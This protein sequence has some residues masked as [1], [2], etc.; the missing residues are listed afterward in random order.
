MTIMSTF[1]KKLLPGDIVLADQGFDI[2]ELIAMEGAELHIPACTRGKKQLS[3]KEVELSKKIEN[4]QIHV[5]RVSDLLRQK[6]YTIVQSTIPITML[7]N[8]A[9]QE[10]PTLD[11]IVNVAC[12]LTNLCPSVVPF[13]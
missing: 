13:H 9:R 12:A 7:L 4:V 5:E 8:K 3:G 10:K 11:K 6:K 2:D 1:V